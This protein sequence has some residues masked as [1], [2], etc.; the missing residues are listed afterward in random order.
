MPHYAVARPRSAHTVA[1]PVRTKSASHPWVVC[2][3]YKAETFSER[4]NVPDQHVCIGWARGKGP[5]LGCIIGDSKL[6][7]HYT[8]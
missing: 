3:A 4:M 7:K 1:F 2:H 6:L 5:W 8:M